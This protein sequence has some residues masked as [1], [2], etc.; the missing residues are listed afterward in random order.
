[1]NPYYT[2]QKYLTEELNKMDYNNPVIVLEFGTGDGSA[3]IFQSF[4][5]RYPNLRI[6]SYETDFEWLRSTF[7]KYNVSNYNFYH[8]DTWDNFPE[9]NEIYS[10]VFVDQSPWDARIETIER[11]KGQTKIFILHDYD[12]FNK[13]VIEDINSVSEGSFYM[14]KWGKEFILEG[15]CELYPGTLI[16]RKR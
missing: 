6:D 8:M 4:A 2:H 14:T 15:N 9:F 10:L 13:G 16:M 12:Y 1:M 3:S 11:L 7:E 5:K